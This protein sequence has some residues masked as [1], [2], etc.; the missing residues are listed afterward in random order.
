VKYKPITNPEAITRLIFE[1]PAELSHRELGERI[2][3]GKDTVA[4]IRCGKKFPDVLP[5]FPRFDKDMA[6]TCI[7][8]LHFN[9]ERIKTWNKEDRT[10]T[11]TPGI[12]ELGIP[13]SEN[14]KF[15]RGC[16]AFTKKPDEHP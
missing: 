1:A 5:H 14:I 10:I 16:G 12:C 7:Q 2:G 8:C 6:R 9:R 11:E 15:A 13:E 4:A 3:V